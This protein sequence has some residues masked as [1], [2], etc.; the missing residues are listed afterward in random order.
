[1]YDFD[2]HTRQLANLETAVRDARQKNV[3]FR[4]PSMRVISVVVSL[5]IAG[6]VFGA[7]VI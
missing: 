7:G 6:T 1:M 3:N 4:M 2:A 5:L